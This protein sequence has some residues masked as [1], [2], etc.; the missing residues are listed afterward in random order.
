MVRNPEPLGA[1]THLWVDGVR[2][3]QPR[4]HH[5]VHVHDL[6]TMRPERVLRGHLSKV[7]SLT[8]EGGRIVSGDGAGKLRRWQLHAA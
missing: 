2:G 3:G 1:L 6:R 8:A 7:H 4:A 5:H